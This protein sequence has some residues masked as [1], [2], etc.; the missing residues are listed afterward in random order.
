MKRCLAS[1]AAL[2]AVIVCVAVLQ[3]V[4][5]IARSDLGIVGSEA[6]CAML[7]FENFNPQNPNNERVSNE[8]LPFAVASLNAYRGNRT[9]V[10]K[11]YDVKWEQLDA[12]I[13]GVTAPQWNGFDMS[14]YQR[15]D[16]S[17]VEILVSFRGT[18][19]IDLR[20]FEFSGVF[21]WVLGNMSWFTQWSY[22][23]QY[24]SARNAFRSVRDWA[25]REHAGRPLFYTVTGHSL[26]GGLSR[27][28]ARAFPCTRAVVFNA[29]CVTNEFRLK[30]PYSTSYIVLINEDRDPLTAQC[31]KYFPAQNDAHTQVYRSANL[32]LASAGAAEILQHSMERYSAGMSRM[33]LCCA[34]RERLKESNS[35][36]CDSRI[37]KPQ[38]D[39]A[40]RLFCSEHH[41]L[42]Q[43]AACDFTGRKALDKSAQCVS[44]TKDC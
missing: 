42:A 38:V 15:D 11:N 19:T 16:G 43:D 23:D 44:K 35:C 28:V 29:S 5:P 14:M 1:I 25:R 24:R 12:K 27:H 41:R 30:E 18:D 26:G 33:V 9:F 31:S 17:R 8:F 2:S 20:T 34:Q 13:L 7:S 39:S 6:S 32:I 21:D 22:L 37:K 4:F 10:L 3:V 36:G 40:F